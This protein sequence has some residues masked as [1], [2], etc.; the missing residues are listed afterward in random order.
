[1]SCSEPSAQK[2][3]SRVPL[4]TLSANGTLD[5]SKSATPE[6]YRL[7]NCDD[8]IENETLTVHEYAEFPKCLFAAISYV[9]QGN[10][11]EN[12]REAE[13]FNVP[14]PEGAAPGDPISIEVLRNACLASREYGAT[15]LWLDRVCIMQTDD[16]DKPWQIKQMYRIYQ[17]CHVCIVLPGGVQCLV[18][19]DQE[20]QWIHRGW[21]LQEVV[22][23]RQDSVFVLFSWGLGSRKARVG[24]V[25]G[26]IRE[27]R[28]SISAMTTLSLI[29]D[30]STTGSMSFENCG[31]WLLVEVRLFSPH[32]PEREYQDFPFWRPTRRVL[33]PNVGALARAMTADLDQDA[34]HHSIWQSALMRTSSRPV[35]MVFSIMGLFGVTLNP[36]DFKKD[37]RVRATIALAQA[38]MKQGGRATW[39]AAAIHVSPSRQISTFPRFPRT[40]VSGKAFVE[41]GGKIQEVSSLMENEYPIAD[42]LVPMPLGSMDDEGYLRFTAKAIPVRALAAKPSAM[43]S[44]TTKPAHVQAI[45]GSWWE[46]HET[47][48]HVEDAAIAVV[49]G[50]FVGYYPGATPAVDST[51]I[52][53]MIVQQ[54]AHE[55]FHVR[56]YAMISHSTKTWVLTWPERILKIGG[57]TSKEPESVT[58]G[59]PLVSVPREQYINNPQSG[60]YNA[61][62]SLQDQEIRR[63]RWAVP[64]EALEREYGKPK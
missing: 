56:S 33:A 57:P 30:A 10:T 27:V 63:A 42:A 11:P 37:D 58:E 44:G 51:N 4:K 36:A 3:I 31:K 15:H 6:R 32:P 25:T 38:V 53:V 16:T 5:I 64:Q 62:P 23:P 7:I 12:G 34:R 43:P 17:R 40:T 54:H 47:S 26:S 14:V 22:A 39:L 20:T 18:R 24:N 46:F 1:M 50:F 9:W 29:I 41:M 45:D 13:A 48:D 8:F 60:P 19:L 61:A 21:T 28:P 49:V 55:K 2:I 59:L 35:D 52:R